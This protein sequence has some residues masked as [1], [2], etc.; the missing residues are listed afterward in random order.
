[1]TSQ[2]IGRAGLAEF[3]LYICGPHEPATPAAPR[4]ASHH[5]LLR[6]T[7]EARTPQH[8]P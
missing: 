1:M 4:D 3:W 2:R 5:Q 8:S 6:F 7:K